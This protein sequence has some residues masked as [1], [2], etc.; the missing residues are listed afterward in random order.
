M[1]D[2]NDLERLVSNER[3]ATYVTEC[4][5]DRLRAASLYKWTGEIGGALLTDFRHLEI[6]YRNTIHNALSQ[7]HNSLTTRLPGAQWFDNPSWVRHHWWDK[8]ATV[9]LDNAI[10]RVGHQPL[11]HPRPSAVVSELNFGFW[12]YIISARYEQSFWLPA[13]D[14]AAWAIPGANPPARRTRLEN[15]IRVLH[16]LRNRIAHHE[17]FFEP[18]TFIGPGKRAL[19]YT[20]DDQAELLHEI[21]HWI[22]PTFAA[23][24][25]TTSNVHTLLADRP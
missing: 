4:K 12:R 20:L 3:F 11:V 10:R 13:L 22:D 24:A 9:A 21:L 7:H 18:T 25:R 2:P 19:L 23:A 14:G 6:V 16:K 15:N 17:P 5:G 1:F 8:H